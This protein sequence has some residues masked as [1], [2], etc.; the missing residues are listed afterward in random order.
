MVLLRLIIFCK[1]TVGKL[2]RADNLRIYVLC[3]EEEAPILGFY[4]LN[5]H[6]V[7]FRELPEKYAKSASR[8]GSI[9]AAYISKIGVT[10]AMQG[11]CWGG[12]L[13]ADALKRI[14]EA[15]EAIGLSVVMMDV[16]DDGDEKN[17]V[18]CLASFDSFDFF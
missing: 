2:Q 3:N 16:L 6:S 13:L 5:A 17:L 9:P 12:V 18:L 11:Q 8:H 1:K 10:S 4:A 7:H 15:A 14:A